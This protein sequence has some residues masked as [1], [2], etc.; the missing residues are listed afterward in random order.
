MEVRRYLNRLANQLRC[1]L[2]PTGKGKITGGEMIERKPKIIA[3]PKKH[4]RSKAALHL[5]R[6]DGRV[7]LFVSVANGHMNT[8][9]TP[10]VDWKYCS[11][12]SVLLKA[13]SPRGSTV[14]NMLEVAES[15]SDMLG[16][17]IIDEVFGIPIDWKPRSK[18]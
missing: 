18:S 14:A 1:G 16:L 8:C 10:G 2:V 13:E 12:K 6:E 5:V 4:T 7:C 17:P 11:P 15:L 9:G 3:A